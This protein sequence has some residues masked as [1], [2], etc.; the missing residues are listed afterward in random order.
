MRSKPWL[1]GVL[2]SSLPAYAA[3]APSCRQSVGA[4]RAAEYVRQCRE[5]S[6]A[7]HPPCNAGNPCSLV[8]SEIKRGCAALGADRPAFCRSY[9]KR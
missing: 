3:A 5:V 8:I 7:T 4:E 1:V 9:R 2:L 6:P